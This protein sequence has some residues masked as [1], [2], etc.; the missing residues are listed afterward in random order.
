MV[1]KH[2]SKDL[3]PV[4]SV[5]VPVYNTEQYLEDAINS[6]LYQDFPSIEIIAV[7]DGSRD[8]SG[9]ILENF[10][11]KDSRIQVYHRENAGLSAA[12]NFGL[13]KANGDYIYFFDSDDIL[14]P[15]AFSR[16]MNLLKGVGGEV[17]AFS[18]RY[19]DEE[20]NWLVT[21]KLL[22]K[23]DIHDP[24]TGQDL[25]VKMMRMGIYS[26]VVS[27]YIYRKSYLQNRHII[28]QEGYIHEDEFFTIKALCLAERAL[29]VSD[30]Y[31]EHRIRDGSIMGNKPGIEN[32]RGWSQAVLQ[33]LDFAEKFP[34][35]PQTEEMVIS[36]ARKLAHN[37][38]RIIHQL[39]KKENKQFS[40]DNFLKKN[41]LKKLGFEIMFRSKYPLMY[42][43]YNR[44]KRV[45]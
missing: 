28:F 15:G 18:G 42:R 5:I 40:T 38:L 6:V 13:D 32:L 12:R 33:L 39:N 1:Q 3:H 35:N 27:M 22:E 29:S 24:I 43:V 45:F 17:I 8:R 7:N 20:G 16:L 19:I 2:L 37:T 23:P 34:L 10:K 26:P 31:Y 9:E 41:D 25:L 30:I 21:D 4:L 36:R 11:K 14:N 44:V